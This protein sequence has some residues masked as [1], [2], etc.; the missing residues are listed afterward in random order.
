M[1]RCV[2]V[3]DV[4]KAVPLII[5]LMGIFHVFHHWWV[6]LHLVEYYRNQFDFNQPSLLNYFM[7]LSTTM[8][9]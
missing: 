7:S 6:N 2:K 5:I 4:V 9:Y 8:N 3:R 1:K